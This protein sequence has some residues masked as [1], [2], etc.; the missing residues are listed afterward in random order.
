MVRSKCLK[1]FWSPIVINFTGSPLPEE[2]FVYIMSVYLV[3]EY[4]WLEHSKK[5]A[6]LFHPN[7]G[8][9]MDKPSHW[10]TFCNDIFNPTFVSIF[11]PNLG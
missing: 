6:G 3:S 4:F 1:N 10:V 7:F 8:S 11:D 5:N 9:N 2:S